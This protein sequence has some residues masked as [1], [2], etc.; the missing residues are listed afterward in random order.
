MCPREKKEDENINI[1]IL[2]AF[3][4]FDYELKNPFLQSEQR[5]KPRNTHAHTHTHKYTQKDK[6]IKA[7][8]FHKAFVFQCDISSEKL[9]AWERY[10]M[11][12]NYPKVKFINSLILLFLLPEFI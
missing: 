11:S 9:W 7:F 4:K 8:P 3:D 1:L 5:K 2:F 12:L 10:G 6:F